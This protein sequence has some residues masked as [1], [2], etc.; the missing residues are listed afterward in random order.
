MSS[1]GP[2]IVMLGL[3]GFPD[4]QGGRMCDGVQLGSGVPI[5]ILSADPAAFEKADAAIRGIGLSA[6]FLGREEIEGPS[7]GF[8]VTY[9]RTE[10]GAAP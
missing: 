9:L 10:A 4:V 6:R 7:R 2:R 8:A 3:R 1:D 5:A